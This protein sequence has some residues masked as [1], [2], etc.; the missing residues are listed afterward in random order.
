[1]FRVGLRR[2]PIFYQEKRKSN[3]GEAFE[4]IDRENRITPSLSQ[5]AQNIRRADVSASLRTNVNSGESPCEISCG[6]RP[7]KI[8]D[9][10][11]GYDQG[12]HEF[13]FAV[14]LTAGWLS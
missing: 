11:T 14:R 3:R 7:E 5:D 8:T 2:G 9:G 12:P 13:L 6:K 10:A 4:D 1:M